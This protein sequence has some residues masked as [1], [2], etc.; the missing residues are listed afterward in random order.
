[1]TAAT[2][3]T[4]PIHA[5]RST[6]LAINRYCRL[7]HK[8]WHRSTILRTEIAAPRLHGVQVPYS[9]G[10]V[11]Y[12][13]WEVYNMTYER[14]VILIVL[15]SFF[16]LCKMASSTVSG[17][18][19]FRLRLKRRSSSHPVWCS[20]ANANRIEWT[21]TMAAGR[22]WVYADLSIEFVFFVCLPWLV[23]KLAK[24][25]CFRRHVEPL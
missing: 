8:K 14:F 3:A 24:F 20:K 18:S 7:H 13:T 6:I 11:Q 25:S 12:S 21:L 17:S 16:N 10:V 4:T 2:T 15:S 5:E 23:W 19:F 1:M 22:R 9:R